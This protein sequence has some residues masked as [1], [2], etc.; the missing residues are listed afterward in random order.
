MMFGCCL[1]QTSCWPRRRNTRVSARNWTKPSQNWPSTSTHHPH[2]T[3]FKPSWNTL[4]GLLQLSLCLSEWLVS[5]VYRWWL[6]VSVSSVSVGYLAVWNHKSASPIIDVA[7]DRKSS[8]L[9]S[10]C[11]YKYSEDNKNKQRNA[12]LSFDDPQ[13]NPLGSRSS[14]PPQTSRCYKHSFRSRER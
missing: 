14:N 6:S 10:D 13:K 2:L 7:V 12:S 11:Y 5:T 8:N 1:V 9:C 3:S 4:P